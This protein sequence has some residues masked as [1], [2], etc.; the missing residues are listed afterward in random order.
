MLHQRLIYV[1]SLSQNKKWKVI[2]ACKRRNNLWWG[3]AKSDRVNDTLKTVGNLAELCLGL[4][5]SELRFIVGDPKK[6]A[7]KARQVSMEIRT[8]LV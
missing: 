1:N 3:R 2:A 5:Q 7:K 4:P 8:T 6:G